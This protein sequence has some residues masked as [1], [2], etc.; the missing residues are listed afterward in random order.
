M[1][2]ERVSLLLNDL[3][4][5]LCAGAAAATLTFMTWEDLKAEQVRVLRLPPADPLHA[6]AW[7]RAR[8]ASRGPVVNAGPPLCSN[9]TAPSTSRILHF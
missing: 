6:R 5:V 7:H 9:C 8:R 3:T 4:D 1:Y 2:C